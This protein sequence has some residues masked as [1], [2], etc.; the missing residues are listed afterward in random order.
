LGIGIDGCRR[1][2]QPLDSPDHF[3][4]RLCVCVVRRCVV[5]AR[6]IT[7]SRSGA[8]PPAGD[9]NRAR[10][11]RARPRTPSCNTYVDPWPRAQPRCL[12]GPRCVVAGCHRDVAGKLLTRMV[13]DAPLA[14]ALARDF[15]TWEPGC[16]VG[17]WLGGSHALGLFRAA[18]HRACRGRRRDL[19]DLNPLASS[20]TP[21][22]LDPGG[23]PVSST[24]LRTIALSAA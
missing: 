3:G 23:A 12:G 14:R 2:A 16:R 7:W 9:T 13:I 17:P 6:G 15:S 19:L 8:R 24:R 11:A 22:P 20:G 18:T 4:G 1:G 10:R 5:S 21:S